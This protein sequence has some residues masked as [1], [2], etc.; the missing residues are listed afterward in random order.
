MFIRRLSA[1]HAQ[2]VRVRPIWC[3]RVFSAMKENIAL[4][5]NGRFFNGFQQ[6]T[7]GIQSTSVTTGSR[8]GYLCCFSFPTEYLWSSEYLCCDRVPTGVPLPL[9]FSNRVPLVFRVPLL[10]QGPNGGTSAAFFSNRVPLVFRVPL[11][12]Q[13]PGGGTTASFLF[14]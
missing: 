5:D 10:Q 12:Q 4:L 11:L 6:G 8:R 1:I 3:V 14:H 7:S 2:L 9:F 13:G